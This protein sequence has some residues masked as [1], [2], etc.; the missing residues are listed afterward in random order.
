MRG[1]QVGRFVSPSVMFD[2]GAVEGGD[3]RQGRCP[4][5][6]AGW[7]GFMAQH[8]D[9]Y[10]VESHPRWRSFKHLARYHKGEDVE[11][12]GNYSLVE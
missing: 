1:P 3:E 11:I 10:F 9:T 8:K 4:A 5:H 2:A 12:D 6:T 7:I